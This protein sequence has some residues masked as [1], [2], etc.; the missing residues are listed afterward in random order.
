MKDL[1]KLKE[2]FGEIVKLITPS[3]HEVVLRQQNGEDDDILSNSFSVS[4][5]TAMMAFLS[6]IIMDSDYNKLGTLSVSEVGNLRIAD[7]Y[8]L[9]VASR[10]FSLGQILN[11]EYKWDDLKSPQAYEED[12]NQFIWDYSKPFP[13][14]ETDNDYCRFRIKPINGESKRE[15]TLRPSGKRIRY[16]YLTVK[17]EQY[18]LKVPEEKQS[19]NQELLARMIEED[20]NGVWKLVE[21]F[22][23]FSAYEMAQIRTDVSINDPGID[24]YSELQH[25][26]KN[27]TVLYP[28]FGSPDFFFPRVI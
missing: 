15:I 8:F 2:N 26:I 23:Y 10:I 22:K 17:G 1:E 5:G 4:Q 27:N 6:N 7:A 13:Q 11:F 12:L 16:N 19:K 9:M 20:V 28:I 18:Y 3:G 24:L 25:P 14:D 21:N